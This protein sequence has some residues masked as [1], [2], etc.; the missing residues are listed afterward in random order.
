M[1][2]NE[3]FNNQ[4]ILLMNNPETSLENNKA[5]EEKIDFNSVIKT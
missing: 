4:D 3:Q 2:Q 1:I 5:I